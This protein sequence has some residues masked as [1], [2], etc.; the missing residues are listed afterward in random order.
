MGPSVKQTLPA[1]TWLDA[2]YWTLVFFAGQKLTKAR[3]KKHARLVGSRMAKI[4]IHFTIIF[5]TYIL[6]ISHFHVKFVNSKIKL[7]CSGMSSLNR[8]GCFARNRNKSYNFAL[9]PFF[10]SFFLSFHV[11]SVFSAALWPNCGLPCCRRRLSEERGTFWKPAPRWLLVSKLSLPSAF[12]GS[13][14]IFTT[15]GNSWISVS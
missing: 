12:P 8:L 4:P 11:C 15:L 2:S 3:V 6:S 14:C 1:F 10:H 13:A 9:I 5:S 7:K